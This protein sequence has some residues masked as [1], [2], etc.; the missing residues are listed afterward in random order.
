MIYQ[1]KFPNPSSRRH[2]KNKH[3]YKGQKLTELVS[4]FK[5]SEIEHTG[6]KES[7]VNTATGRV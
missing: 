4:T 6:Y 1:C 2:I 3:T 7:K 5:G